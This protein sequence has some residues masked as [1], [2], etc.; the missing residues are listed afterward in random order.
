MSLLISLSSA[1]L[2]YLY[3]Y[4]L[5]RLRDTDVLKFLIQADFVL[6]ANREAV[7]DS[8]WNQALREGVA[9][10]FCA[11]AGKF[12]TRGD[13]LEFKWMHYLPVQHIEGF[14]EELYEEIEDHLQYQQIL[15]SRRGRLR[16]LE[17]VRE[18]PSWFLH[19]QKPLV[20]DNG[21]DIYLFSEYKAAEIGL[22]KSLG[23]KQIAA[24]EIVARLKLSLSSGNNPIHKR[25]LDDRWHTAFAAFAGKLMRDKAIKNDV[26]Q[27]E[28]IPLNDE[29][30]VSPSSMDSNPVY[31]PYVVDEDSVRIELPEG[32]GLRKLHPTAFADGE[33][34]SFYIS[35]GISTCSHEV[36]IRNILEAHKA[37]KRSGNVYDFV[38]DLEILFWFGTPMEFR[39]FG[40]GSTTHA[41]LWLVSDQNK[42]YQGRSLFFP[43]DEEYHAQKLLA[44]TPSIDFIDFGFLDPRYLKSQVRYKICHQSDWLSWLRKCGI[45]YFPPLLKWT[46]VGYVLSPAMKLI[47]RD[48]PD[49][50]VANLKEHW[51]DYQF[52]ST[53][54]AKDLGSLPVPCQD[55][56]KQP[57][58]TT[59]LP[60]Q[61]LLE[62][63]RQL[64]IEPRLPF[65]KLPSQSD[66]Q[67]LESWSFLG[68]FGVTCDV[69]AAFY[70]AALRLLNTSTEKHLVSICTFIYAG[71]VECTKVGDARA[72]QVS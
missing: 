70:L 12:T 27:L 46:S 26:Q 1:C 43:S 33:R 60:T 28:I 2:N 16:L 3:V 63:S 15:R 68:N 54:V 39:G 22:L 71:I 34:V 44:A 38:R 50:F 19:E 7:P 72:L 61:Q 8:D 10:T 20:P 65:L 11:A 40:S 53:M 36:A 9:A 13:S 45:L 41:D 32:L 14:W 62:K 25:P 49:K 56:T 69:N 23:L 42:L 51:S 6:A 29:S 5:V 24:K 66:I 47:A 55:G 58:S 59:I 4:Q 67:R 17:I 48:S 52:E 64:K 21:E 31:F 18:L 37:V 35:L 30:W 57:L